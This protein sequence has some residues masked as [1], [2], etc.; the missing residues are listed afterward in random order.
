MR[1]TVGQLRRIVREALEAGLVREAP[2]SDD[3]ILTVDAR[4]ESGKAAFAPDLLRKIER[5]FG[6]SN[7]RNK[8]EYTLR[9]FPQEVILINAIIDSEN[10]RYD[11]PVTNE[12][13]TAYE[14]DAGIE[15]LKRIGVSSDPAYFKELRSKLGGGAT[16]FVNVTGDLVKGDLPT[17]WMMLHAMFDN[18]DYSFSPVSEIRDAV[19]DIY[20][21]SGL[22]Y[23]N[24]IR[25]ATMKSARDNNIVDEDIVTEM[26]VQSI[27]DSRGLTFKETDDP[28]MSKKLAEIKQKIDK[29]GIRQTIHRATAGKVI[30]IAT[31]TLA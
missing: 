15:M 22:G 8:A 9:M 5:F 24:I 23:K 11:N 25:H 1:M 26:I 13:L 19:F 20:V 14:P 29:L 30:A 7:Y 12:R 31:G 2:L 3:P 18:G 28:E 27:V 17:P 16:V 4:T 6:N 21:D 10:H